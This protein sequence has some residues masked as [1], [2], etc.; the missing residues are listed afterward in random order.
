MVPLPRRAAS[1]A[2]CVLVSSVSVIGLPSTA[3]LVTR[4]AFGLSLEVTGNPDVPPNTSLVLSLQPTQSGV[5][6]AT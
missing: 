2:F 4:G 3:G 6:T 1:A 5:V